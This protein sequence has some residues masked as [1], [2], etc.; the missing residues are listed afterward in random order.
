MTYLDGEGGARGVAD[1]LRQ[2]RYH[3]AGQPQ[4]AEPEEHQRLTGEVPAHAH[5]DGRADHLHIQHGVQTD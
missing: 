2:D 4:H 5:E 3:D 1:G